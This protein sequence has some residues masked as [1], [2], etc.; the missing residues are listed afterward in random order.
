MY[1]PKVRPGS[2]RLR[3]MEPHRRHVQHLRRLELCLKQ[4]DAGSGARIGGCVQV[5]PVQRRLSAGRVPRRQHIHLTKRIGRCQQP[6]LLAQDLMSASTQ[7]VRSS[8]EA[9][10]TFG[11]SADSA[12][13]LS[14][15]V[16]I[17]VKVRPCP[18]ARAAVPKVSDRSGLRLRY[19]GVPEKISTRLHVSLCK[20]QV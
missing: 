12:T 11:S 2:D 20:E 6:A 19:R 13:Y 18:R 17:E 14:E 10:T 9:R 3:R 4:A 8:R 5:R 16:L 7:P 15:E 1:A